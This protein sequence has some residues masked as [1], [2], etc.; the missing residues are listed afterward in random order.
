MRRTI[1]VVTGDRADYG[2]SLPILRR[3][4]ADPALALALYVTGSHLAPAFG[5]TVEA[6]EADGMPIAERVEMLEPS[7]APE[8][9]AVSM[10]R[11]VIGFARAFARRRPDLL[12]VVADRFEMQAAALAALPFTIPL[13]HVHGGEL[14]AGA[15]DDAL[16]HALT[17]F[18]HLH[19]VATEAYARRVIQMGEEPWRVVVTGAPS[20]DTLRALPLLSP[21]ELRAR[22]GIR[23]EPP[24]LLVTYHPVTLEYEDASWQIGQLL[25]A[26]EAADRPVVFTRTN[27][28]TGGR[29]VW[30]A[31]E[32]FAARRPSAQI[33]A[34]LGAQA[35]FSLM[36]AAAAM[37]G[38]SSS[39]L[40][41]APSIGLP[42][43]NIGTRQDG[44]VRAE[45][46]IDV[47]YRRDEILRGITAA[48]S[49]E[50][51]GR[52]RGLANPY[53]DGRASE[54]IVKVLKEVPLDAR[55]IRKRFVD[56]TPAPRVAADTPGTV[57]N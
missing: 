46:V 16:R 45:N 34:H 49:P 52:L 27:A 41:E 43:V 47:G 39:A 35:Y 26:L 4:H 14:T 37:V 10:G 9:I 36:A 48:L 17:K 15:M 51:R 11:G 53:G 24:P 1:G 5:R 29:A 44:R 19:F 3:I 32:A 50:F 21:E 55:L 7:D 13:A 23:L 20:L 31:I 40:V 56:G 22:F 57:P 54:A 8:G 6:I 2:V 33:V 28:D 25:A 38:N 18:S 42:V 12:L 30:G